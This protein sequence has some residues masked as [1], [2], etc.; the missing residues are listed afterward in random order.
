MKIIVTGSTGNISKPLAQ[1]LVA[2]GHNVTVISSNA[3]K[4]SRN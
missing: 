3:D 2:A 4:S 1:T